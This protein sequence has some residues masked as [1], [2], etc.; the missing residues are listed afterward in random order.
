MAARGRLRDKARDAERA[1]GAHRDVGQLDLD[2]GPLGHRVD[3]REKGVGR[4]CGRLVR[5]RVHDLRRELPP[6]GR[7]EPPDTAHCLGFVLMSALKVIMSESNKREKK[8]HEKD[9]SW[10]TIHKSGPI[11]GQPSQRGDT[12]AISI[13]RALRLRD[14]EAD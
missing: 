14:F 5:V 10:R 12:H 13:A 4:Q 1:S 7:A 3:D 9:L 8:T 11:S 2:V 6:A